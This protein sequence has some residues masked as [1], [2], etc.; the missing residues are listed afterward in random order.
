MNKISTPAQ[1]ICSLLL[2]CLLLVITPTYATTNTTIA[3][4]QSNVVTP[5][6][7]PASTPTPEITAPTLSHMNWIVTMNNV[8]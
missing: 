4:K 1:F 2:P 8:E 3:V 7:T 6:A 5:V